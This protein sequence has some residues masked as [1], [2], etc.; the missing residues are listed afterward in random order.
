MEYR[1]KQTILNKEISN[2]RG[3]LKEMFNILN[4]Q[5][6]ANQNHSEILPYANWDG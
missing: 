4:H 6:N 2:G 1:A 3:T 5:V